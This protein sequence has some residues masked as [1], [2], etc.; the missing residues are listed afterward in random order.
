MRVT[1]SSSTMVSTSRRGTYRLEPPARRPERGKMDSETIY[2]HTITERSKGSASLIRAAICLIL[3]GLSLAGAGCRDVATTWTAE[4]RSPDGLWLATARSQQWGG[5]GTA[6]DATTVYLK[7]VRGSQPPTQILGFSHQ[8]GTMTLKMDWVTP[9][10]LDVAYGPSGR[11][12]DQVNVDFQAVRCGNIT[13]SLRKLPS[14][15]PDIPH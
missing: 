15:T 6:Y 2:A 14:E 13:I 5:P 3:I 9:T 12:G 10:H 4:T 8:Y 1:K 7:W 11:P